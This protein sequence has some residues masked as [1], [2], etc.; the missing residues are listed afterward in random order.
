MGAQIGTLNFIRMD[1]SRNLQGEAVRRLER[2]G[3]DGVALQKLG[4]RATPTRART[5]VDV[6]DQAAIATL[7]SAANTYRGTIVT[8]V[9]DDGTSVSGVCVINCV[10]VQ[11]RYVLTPVGGINGGN[12]LVTLDWVLQETTIV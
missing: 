1:W 2:P 5:I 7:V 6:I 10:K 12:W 11:S 4:K 8:V 3:G 9:E